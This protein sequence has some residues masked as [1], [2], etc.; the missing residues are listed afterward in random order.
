MFLATHSY[1]HGHISQL[2]WAVLLLKQRVAVAGATSAGVITQAAQLLVAV[3]YIRYEI[4]AD[5]FHGLFVALRYYVTN[6]PRSPNPRWNYQPSTS[7]PKQR[8]RET[9]TLNTI[10][11]D[12]LNQDSISLTAVMVR[13][14]PSFYSSRGVG[15]F[16][17]DLTGFFWG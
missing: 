5:L 7:Q 11:G 15:L 13:R 1:L 14:A 3:W 17:L 4:Q 10:S 6:T 8:E 16:W 9:E 2:R 12:P